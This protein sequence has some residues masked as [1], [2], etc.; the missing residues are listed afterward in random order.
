MRRITWLITGVTLFLM[1]LGLLVV[2]T[3]TPICA[4]QAQ[5][6]PAGTCG[7]VIATIRQSVEIKRKNLTGDHVCLGNR[8]V[9]VSTKDPTGATASTAI[10][11]L[12][13]ITSIFTDSLEP[14]Q[15]A[16]GMAIVKARIDGTIDDRQAATF[17]LY[18]QASISK[19]EPPSSGAMPFNL[20]HLQ[21]FYFQPGA[22]CSRA[23]R[24]C[25]VVGC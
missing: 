11:A 23:V 21:A 22:V 12:D 7:Q 24:S 8:P 9:T 19:A 5:V 13:A 18:G 2:A 16:W 3:A 17:T 1:A 25:R 15:G 10:I 14:A 4:Q 20:T 6:T